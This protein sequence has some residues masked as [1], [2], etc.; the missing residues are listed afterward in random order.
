M[1]KILQLFRNA[2]DFILAFA[3]LCMAHFEGEDDAQETK[4]R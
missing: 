1:K 3:L 4:T 2:W